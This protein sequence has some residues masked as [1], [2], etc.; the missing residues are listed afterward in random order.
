MIHLDTE[1]GQ[2]KLAIIEMM[3]LVD[4]QLEK[5][6]EAYINMDTDLAEEIIHTEKRVNA[7]EISIDRDCENLFALLTPVATDLR[8]VISVLKMNSDLERIGDYAENIATYVIA[9]ESQFSIEHIKKVQLV[10]MFDIAT[11]M[12]KDIKRAFKEDD[13]KLARKVFKKDKKLNKIN[14]N[15]S[16]IIATIVKEN[17]AQIRPSLFLFSTIRKLER[18]GD[19]IKNIAENIIFSIEAKVLKHKK[20]QL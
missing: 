17:P 10:E 15:T 6:K 5:S 1:L 20:N 18:V 12:F 4:H 16:K 9:I 2:L 7:M 19:H 13:T 3:E 11:E 14:T 8:F